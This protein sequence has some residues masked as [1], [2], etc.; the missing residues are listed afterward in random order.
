MSK[1]RREGEDNPKV[2]GNENTVRYKRQCAIT[3]VLTTYR[4]QNGSW[5]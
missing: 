3:C 4:S 1:I 2:E 5:C